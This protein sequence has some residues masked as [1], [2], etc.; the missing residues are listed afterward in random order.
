MDDLK[1][2]LQKKIFL[3][4]AESLYLEYCKWKL[5]EGVEPEKL[6]FSNHWLKDW[7]KEY[8][9]S[10]KKPNKRFLINAST[11]KKRVADFLKNIWIVKILS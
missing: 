9:I 2:R 7:R 10:I 11:R 3:A 6:T 4:K 5:E 1:E 8:Q